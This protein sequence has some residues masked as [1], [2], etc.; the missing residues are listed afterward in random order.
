MSEW[1]KGWNESENRGSTSLSLLNLDARTNAKIFLIL[2][3][4]HNKTPDFF[5]ERPLVL[6]C[7]TETAV[8]VLSLEAG[9]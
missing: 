9:C 2:L 5:Y 6:S 1:R 7:V 4:L 3:C 8:E